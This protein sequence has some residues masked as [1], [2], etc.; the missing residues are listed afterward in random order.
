MS[1]H[2]LAGGVLAP[3]RTLGCAAARPSPA[4]TGRA[5]MVRASALRAATRTPLSPRPWQRGGLAIRAQWRRRQDPQL[6]PHAAHAGLRAGAL[7]QMR[8]REGRDTGPVFATRDGGELDAANVRSEF[9]GAVK[10][11]GIPGAWTRANSVT[12][13]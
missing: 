2:A 13:S 1:V 12:P 3:A 6:M 10:G 9:R 7:R 8:E 5:W 11:T 4:L